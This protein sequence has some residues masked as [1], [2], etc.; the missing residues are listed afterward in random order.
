MIVLSRVTGLFKTFSV[1]CI[2]DLL[3]LQYVHNGQFVQANE[4]CLFVC[5]FCFPLASLLGIHELEYVYEAKTFENTHG[6]ALVCG[7]LHATLGHEFPL[8]QDCSSGL[9]VQSL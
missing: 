2:I 5:L 9:S 8:A 3:D 6:W 1:L 7:L 4:V